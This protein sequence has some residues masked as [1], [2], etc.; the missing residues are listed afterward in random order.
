MIG[1]PNS[2]GNP[3]VPCAAI[4]RS[5][6]G[7]FPGGSKVGVTTAFSRGLTSSIRAML[8]STASAEVSSPARMAAAICAAPIW[9]TGRSVLSRA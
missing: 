1:T 4:C 3:S 8:A 7:G 5:A 6:G 9:T 2:G